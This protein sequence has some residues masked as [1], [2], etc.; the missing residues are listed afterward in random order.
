MNKTKKSLAFFLLLSSIIL[1]LLPAITVAQEDTVV[2]KHAASALPDEWD[3]AV[4]DWYNVIWGSYGVYA[5]EVLI[6]QNAAYTAG[7]TGP[8]EDEWIGQLATDWNLT[9]RVEEENDSGFN[10]TG[11]IESAVFKL[12]EGVTFHDG[13]DWNAT[14]AK[15]N[16]DRINL[17]AGNYTGLCEATADNDAEGNLMHTIVLEDYKPYWS[18]NWNMTAAG[19]DSPNLGMSPPAILPDVNDYAWYNLGD[20]ASLVDYGDAVNALILPNNTLR[21]PA[22]YGGWDFV[23]AAAIHYAPYDRYPI[24]N[25][26]EIMDNK[27]SGGTIRVFYNQWTVSGLTGGVNHPMISY[28]SYRKNYTTRGIYGYENGV[29][30]PRN[31]GPVTHMLGTGPYYYVEHDETG[32]PAGGYMLKFEDYWN[33]TA[34]EADGWFDVDRF[35]IINFPTGSLGEDA[36]NTAMLTHAIDFAYDSMYMPLDYDAIQAEDRIRYESTGPTTYKTNIVLNS[37]NETWWAWPWADGWRQGFYPLAGDKPAGG[38]PRALRKSMGYAFNYDLMIHTVLDDRAVRGGGVIGAQNI[39]FNETLDDPEY[40]AHYN[41]TKAREILLTTETDISGEVYTGIGLANGYNPPADLYNF[42]KMCADRSLTAMSTDQDWQYV[43]DNN[44]IFT[45]NFYWDSAHEDVKNVFLTS[46]RNI[47]CTLKDKTGATNRVTTIIWDTVRIGHLTTFDGTHSLFSC[48]AWVMDEDLPH[49]SPELNL[50][51]AHVDPDKGRWRTL[52]SG[53][54]TSWHYWGNYGFNFNADADY[55]NDR[56]WTS[57]PMERKQWISALAEVEQTVVYSKIWCYEAVGGWALWKD[58]EYFTIENRG[59][60]QDG[61]Y[62][63]LNIHMMNYVG[64]PEDYALIPGAPLVITLAISAV[65]MIGIVYAI[66][67]RKKL[68]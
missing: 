51:W 29:D 67:R 36:K 41:L 26:V 4:T 68:Y 30:D 52:G 32:T 13:S 25:R 23:S 66:M 50:F 38:V 46:L 6:G 3:P 42:S 44:P 63:G 17:V 16:I 65:S 53:G 45:V 24:I 12:R 1:P 15:W 35:E 59:G 10:N 14:V 18:D 11:G 31:A 5:T 33:K 55:Y 47:G 27:Q 20:N 19:Y 48:N 58:W 34:L 9:R 2:F 56:M 64:L 22:P 61:F 57:D 28:H 49:A 40:L 37:I 60:Y 7:T 21:N 43:A 54:I 8:I 39:Y 62:G